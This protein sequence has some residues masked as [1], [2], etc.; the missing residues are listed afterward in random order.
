M[1]TAFII[2]YVEVGDV[3]LDIL[4]EPR[5][6]LPVLSAVAD[7]SPFALSLPNKQNSTD[8]IT[9]GEFRSVGC[10]SSRFKAYLVENVTY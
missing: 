1:I 9:V 10:F 5:S 6:I 4:L 3:V 7:L 8:M 2:K